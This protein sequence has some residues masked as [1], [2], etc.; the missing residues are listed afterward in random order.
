MEKRVPSKTKRGPSG[1][2]RGPSGREEPEKPKG[3]GFGKMN[4]SVL[5]DHPGCTAGP[6]ATAV[7][8]I[9]QRI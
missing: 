3:D 5:A 6:S 9:W 4:L 8:D 1:L 7:P 2:R